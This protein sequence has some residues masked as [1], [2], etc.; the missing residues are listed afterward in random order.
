MAEIARTALDMARERIRAEAV[1]R[2]GILDLRG[3]DLEIRLV[4]GTRLRSLS[5][6]SA[7]HRLVYFDFS[8]TQ[9]DDPAPIANLQAL[10][11][12]DCSGTEAA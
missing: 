10:R 3:L 5:S 6:I 11:T 4:R 9:V 2:T 8:G 12:L 1:A 7:P